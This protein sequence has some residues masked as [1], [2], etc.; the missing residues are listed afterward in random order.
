M[1]SLPHSRQ[2]I[3]TLA[4]PHLAILNEKKLLALYPPVH[5]SNYT[6]E[7]YV[8]REIAKKE[9]IDTVGNILDGKKAEQN[10]DLIPGSCQAK[11]GAEAQPRHSV[12]V[13]PI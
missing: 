11:R 3:V 1:K 4:A 9:E 8:T 5:S 13:A 7:L 2:D 6:T 10:F 12:Q